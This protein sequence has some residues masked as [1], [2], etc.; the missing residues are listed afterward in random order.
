MA[1]TTPVIMALLL[2]WISFKC[3]PSIREGIAFFF[4]FTS[5]PQR[6]EQYLD[7]KVSC[8]FIS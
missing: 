7:L 5:V 1:F 2:E 3:K 8:V 4:Q 6:V